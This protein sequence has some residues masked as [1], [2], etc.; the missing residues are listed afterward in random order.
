MCAVL[1][2]K[3][4][5]SHGLDPSTRFWS[6]VERGGGAGLVQAI[7]VVC[8]EWVN[9]DMVIAWNFYLRTSL[10]YRQRYIVVFLLANYC[11]SLNVV[12]MLRDLFCVGSGDLGFRSFT[13]STLVGTLDLL[14]CDFNNTF[15]QSD[16]I[17]RFVSVSRYGE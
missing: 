5:E 6:R 10:L 7:F 8:G 9:P 16:V 15:I 11:K 17:Q 12:K 3:R 13:S 14:F 1:N 2:V 4:G